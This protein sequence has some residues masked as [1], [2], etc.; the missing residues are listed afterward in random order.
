M[1]KYGKLFL[2]PSYLDDTNSKS[3][4]APSIYEVI[5]NVE[6]Y[7]VE[8]V[9]TSRRYISSLNL[10]L[11]IEQL[12]FE[13]LTKK[14]TS[15]DIGK[16]LEP[17]FNG[18]DVGVISEAGLPGIAD[19]GKLAVEYAHKNGIQVIPLPGASSIIL[20]LVA[21]GFNGQK[22]TFHGYLPIEKV[23]REQA[24][25]ILEKRALSTGETQVFMETPYR[26]NQLLES[27]TNVLK[28]DTKVSIASNIT[29]TSEFIRTLTV[30]NWKTLK[31]NIHKQPTI[32][33]VGT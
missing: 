7:I 31:P 20:A 11:V 1:S 9:R 22:F 15:S 25:R 26:N 24:I 14:S 16:L 30:A 21:S 12:N 32:F 33:S 18:F 19:P 5:R 13:L 8:N 10:G 23:A 4:I 2:I 17:V 6:Y 28:P 27:L 29:G 3:I